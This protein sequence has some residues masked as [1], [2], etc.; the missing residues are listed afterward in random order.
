MPVT[1]LLSTVT[2]YDTASEA[3][4]G[5]GLDPAQVSATRPSSE[6]IQ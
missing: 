5:I 1:F 4:H 2:K 3:V 6:V